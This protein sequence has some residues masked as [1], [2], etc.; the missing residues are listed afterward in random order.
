MNYREI[1]D[2]LFPSRQ[3]LLQADVLRRL[4]ESGPAS[5]RDL[6]IALKRRKSD[7]QHALHGLVD[8]KLVRRETGGMQRW[9]ATPDGFDAV[10][11][12]R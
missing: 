2:K 6:G 8:A 11:R 4:S 5:S 3:Q 9:K 7:I 12:A 1:F 10:K